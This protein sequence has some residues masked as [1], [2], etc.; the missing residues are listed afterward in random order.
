MRRRGFQAGQSGFTLV[1]VMA[2]ALVLVIGMLSV[3]SVLRTGLSKTTLNRQRVTATNLTRELTETARSATY[4]QLTNGRMTAEIQS[5]DPTLLSRSGT[6]WVV[7]RG[8]T[9]FTIAPSACT[10]DDPADNIAAPPP[11]EKCSNNPA[12]TTGDVN[13]DDFRRLTFDISWRNGQEGRNYSLRQTALIVNP[14]GGIGPR[15]TAF[16]NPGTV[17][18]GSTTASFTVT[19][20]TAAGIHWNADDGVSEGDAGG[21]PTSWT[22]NWNLLPVGTSNAVLDGTYT[23]SAQAVDDRGVAG[24]T[25]LASVTVNRSAPFAPSNFNGGHDTRAGDWVDLDWSLNAERDITGYRV[26]WAGPD[27]T[28]DTPDDVRVCPAAGASADRLGKSATSCQHL[29]PPAGSAKYAI[30]ALDETQSGAR[31]VLTVASPSSRPNPPASLVASGTDGATLTWTAPGSG[32][33]AFYR[34]YRDGLAVADRI[35]KTPALTYTDASD[36]T[37]HSYYVTAVDSAYNESDPVGPV[38]WNP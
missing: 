23:V 33:V 34:V 32:A 22:I 4:A 11:S 12:G 15:I 16:P 17:G 9:N 13:G 1:E 6:A 3:L 38:Q 26:F 21:G 10:F 8:L 35:L 7:K 5:Q 2:A 37:S 20:T 31:S 28:L 18:P 14:A 29:D 27:N 24:D 19:S 25:K 30:Y 36:G